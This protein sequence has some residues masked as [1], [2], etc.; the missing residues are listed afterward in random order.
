MMLDENGGGMAGNDL[1]TLIE[2]RIPEHRAHLET[3]HLNL[4]NVAAY[5][6][7]NYL[8]AIVSI[9]RFQWNFF[10]ITY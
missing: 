1:R 2:S 3:S 4:E 6:E 5:C 10:M 9:F 8:K 7:G